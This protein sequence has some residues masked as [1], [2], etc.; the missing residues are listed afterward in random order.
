MFS[1][2][3]QNGTPAGTVRTSRRRQRPASN[4]GS[5]PKAKRQ[6]SALT[7]NTFRPE[8]DTVEMEEVKSSQ[9]I[10][11]LARR[12]SQ[13][14]TPI[15]PKEIPVRGKKQ[16]SGERSNKGDGSVIL[17]RIWTWFPPGLAAANF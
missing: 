10:A 16:R 4:E 9:K 14:E 11:A 13:R 17:V 1:K 5:I 7:E 15:P 6:R 2:Q 3:G 8:D 12:D